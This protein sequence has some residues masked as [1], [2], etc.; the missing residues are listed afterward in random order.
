MVVGVGVRGSLIPIDPSQALMERLTAIIKTIRSICLDMRDIFSYS[1]IRYLL[2][3][4]SALNGLRRSRAHP[5]SIAFTGAAF[6]LLDT[7]VP[8][9]SAFRS[10]FCPRLKS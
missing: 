10:R 9:A 8:Q 2:S 3:A 6:Q 5:G 4:P 7:T 1:F